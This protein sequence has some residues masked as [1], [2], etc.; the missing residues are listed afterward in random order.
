MVCACSNPACKKTRPNWRPCAMLQDKGLQ[1]LNA[2]NTLH[3]SLT[4]TLKALFIK[5]A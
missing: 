3:C 5:L 4:K 1:P 2:A